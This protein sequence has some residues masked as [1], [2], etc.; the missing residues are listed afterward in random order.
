M[1]KKH[2][3]VSLVA[4]AAVFFSAGGALAQSSCSGRHAKCAQRC[5]ADH[6]TTVWR[7]AAEDRAKLIAFLQSPSANQ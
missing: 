7:T 5:H 3:V 1:A 4:L 2:L 6:P